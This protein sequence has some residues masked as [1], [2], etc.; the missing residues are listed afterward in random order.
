MKQI[1]FFCWLFSVTTLSA[2][3]LTR[4]NY[5]VEEGLPSSEA[6]DI[7]QDKEG[8][9]WFATDNGIVKF[10]GKEMKTFHLKDGLTD[11]VVFEFKPDAKGR[12]WFR[13]FSGRLSYIEN[14][15]IKVYPYND[16]LERIG[17]HG[18]IYFNYSS[19]NDDL[20]FTVR[21]LLG[22]I[23]SKGQT[24][25]DSSYA[26]FSYNRTLAYKTIGDGGLIV[27]SLRY[28]PIQG[29]KIDEMVFPLKLT[30]S[31]FANQVFGQ[32]KWNNKLYLS[33]QNDILEFDGKQLRIAYSSEKPIISITV[34]REG[35]FWVGFRSGGAK[36]FATPSFDSFFEPKFLSGQSVSKVLQS[37]DNSHWF[38]TLETGIYY[39]ANLSISNYSIAGKAQIKDVKSSRN[40]IVV[41]DKTG[42]VHFYDRKTKEVYR[43][44]SFPYNILT[45]A[46]DSRDIL[47]VSSHSHISV[48]A[49]TGDSKIQYDRSAYDFFEEVG[50]TMW[51]LG[52]SRLMKFNRRLQLENITVFTDLYRNLV[53]HDSS[54]FLSR[55]IGLHVRNRELALTKA[56]EEF[57]NYKIS[58]MVSMN[59]SILLVATMGN[60]FHLLNTRTWKK[61]TYD[62]GHNFIASNIY[63]VLKN[64]SLLWIGTENGLA[65]TPINSLLRGRP[66]FNFLSRK[67]G[68]VSNMINFLAAGDNSIWAFSSDGFSVIPNSF[69]RFANKSPTFYIKSILVNGEACPINDQLELKPHQDN[70]RFD[71][72]FISFNN[73]NIFL[74]YKIQEHDPW[75]NLNGNERNVQLSSLAPAEYK[76]LLQ[77]SADNINWAPAIAPVSFLIDSPWWAKWYFYVVLVFVLLTLGYFYFRYQRTIYKQKHHYLRIINEHQQKLLNSEVETLE[78]ERNRIAKELH[79]RVGTNLTAIKLRVNQIL[80]TNNNADSGDVEDQFQVAIKEIKEI[81][82]DLTPP[83]LE[84]YGLFTGLR[85]YVGK[86]DKRIPLNISLKTFG[87]ELYNYELN[88]LIFRVLQELLNNSIK[89]SF[90]KNITIHI[91]AFDDL[92]NIVYEDDGVGFQYDPVK[93]GLGLNN[94]DA[95]IQSVS[96][97]LKFES[98]TYG[99]SYTIDIPLKQSELKQK[100]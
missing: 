44:K 6:Y 15:E 18:L 1:I 43:S 76:F 56:P 4:Y 92:V 96:G 84:R 37:N 19:E 48:M 82:Y 61:A 68:L 100:T 9:M 85:N 88:I 64:D 28:L 20:W 3:T 55:R 22:H 40:Y 52:N 33:M 83:S 25:I 14:G 24:T 71:F 65:V 26:N 50:G 62:L 90:A 67:S 8:F 41:G 97:T 5:S 58:K 99:V 27:N 69:N 59:D 95:R 63:S 80:R 81:I 16:T 87:S 72:G 89:H 86:L 75:I 51:G 32:V 53:I 54:F 77:Y 73:Q 49:E 34:D 12:I 47:W 70:I 57:N 39:L 79:D 98:G 94:I 60:G 29:V 78:R 17:N 10:D 21:N 45:L 35:F 31:T 66:E 46:V 2:Q 74:R 13:T 7:F 23:D 42:G 11:P 30:E 93:S 38:S 36:R 91:S